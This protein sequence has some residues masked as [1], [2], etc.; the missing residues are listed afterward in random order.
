MQSTQKD[1]LIAISSVTKV[2]RDKKKIY[3]IYMQIS[4]T[5]DNRGIRPED[6]HLSNLFAFQKSLNKP[7]QLL[8]FGFL[9]PTFRENTFH[10]NYIW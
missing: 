10:F 1:A 3:I 5:E 7:S 6:N 9:L 8:I 4:F 2:S